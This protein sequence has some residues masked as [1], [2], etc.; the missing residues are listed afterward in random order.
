MVDPKG[1]FYCGSPIL[2]DGVPS[3]N[4]SAIFPG[5]RSYNWGPEKVK[6]TT[7]IKSIRRK[8]LD[9]QAGS[10]KAVR[11]CQQDECPLHPYRMGHDPKRQ[12]KGKISNLT[13]KRPTRVESFS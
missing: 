1:C 11:T 2:I 5:D 6:M 13:T 10:R 9:C 8:C 4:R 3:N 12:G 7:P